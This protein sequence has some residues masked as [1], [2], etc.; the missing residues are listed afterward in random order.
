[1]F[2]CNGSPE[3]MVLRS[4]FLATVF[5]I[6]PALQLAALSATPDSFLS[7]ILPHRALTDAIAKFAYDTLQ[8]FQK[9]P[10]CVPGCDLFCNDDLATVLPPFTPKN[11]ML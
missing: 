3:L 1:M 9:K 2:G 7:L 10:L 6:A 4:T 11:S 5:Q 8:I